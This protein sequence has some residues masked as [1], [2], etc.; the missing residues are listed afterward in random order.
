MGSGLG[1]P[2]DTQLGIHRSL[3]PYFDNATEYL[4]ELKRM[5]LSARPTVTVD[6]DEGEEEQDRRITLLMVAGG[7]FAGMVVSL[8]PRGKTDKQ[9]IKGAGEVKVLKHKT[10]HRYTSES[11]GYC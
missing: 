4:H 10:F 1:F 3:F 8:N 11:G 2:R 7:H 9:L 5:Q 6:T